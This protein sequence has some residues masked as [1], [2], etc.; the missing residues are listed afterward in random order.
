M[1]SKRAAFVGVISTIRASATA[2]EDIRTNS[3]ADCQKFASKFDNT[4]TSTSAQL[5]FDAVPTATV[6]CAGN[7]ICG[8]GSEFTADARGGCAWTRKLCVT[9]YTNSA[10]SKTKI[11]V[12]SNG[13]PNHCYTTQNKVKAMDIDFEVNWQ[14]PAIA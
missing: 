12:Q 5:A 7:Q 6:T 10:S 11:R 1:F 14:S 8:T 13:L 4:C 9:C 3:L 2:D